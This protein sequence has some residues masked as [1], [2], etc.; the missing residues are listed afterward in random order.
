[1]PTHKKGHDKDK[2]YH[3]AKDQGYRSR[4]AYKLIQINKRYDFLGKAR[5]CI[6][7]CAAPGG[8]CQVASKF[9]P[10][11]SIVLGVDLLPIR[12]IRNVKTIVA[13]ITTAECR[14]QVTGELH[15]WKADVV[16][17]DGAPNIGSAYQKDAYVQN[18]LV[19]AALKCA[20]EH[21]IE[22]GTFCTKVYRSKDYNAVLW[23]LQQ[24]F[25]DV[26]AMKPNSSR[27]Q[28]SEIFLVCLKYLAPSTIDPKLLDPNHVF[29]EVQDPSDVTV[30]VLHKKY[31][32]HNKR[33]R[34]GYDESAGILLT[35]TCTVQ[36]F[37]ASKDPVRLLTDMNAFTYTP[38]CKELY[39][40][41]PATTED[42][43]LAF[44][45]LRV[46]GRIDFKKLLKWRLHIIK[47]KEKQKAS[48]DDSPED[49]EGN[50]E[51]SKKRTHQDKTPLTEEEIQI[52][53][54]Q[55][56]ENMDRQ[57][58]KEKKKTRLQAA[59]ERSR[60]A[61][62][63]SNASFGVEQDMELFSL[64]NEG[65]QT[66]SDLG[67]VD[68]VGLDE[69]PPDFDEAENESSSD[70][71]GADTGGLIELEEDGLEDQLEQD[72]LR[73]ASRERARKERALLSE[74][75]NVE[76]DIREGL[77]DRVLSTKKTKKQESSEGR[78]ASRVDEDDVLEGGDGQVKEDLDNYV[79]LLS[80]KKKV[81]GGSD[82]D[83]DSGSN[84]SDGDSEE[85]NEDSASED[86]EEVTRPKKKGK[87]DQADVVVSRD[88]QSS[89]TKANLWFSNP[90]FKETVV[91]SSEAGADS[92][93]A[94]KASKRSV[95]QKEDK[96]L[97]DLNLPLTDKQIRSL[98]RKKDMDK[99]ERKEERRQK[100]R[101][102]LS[103][104]DEGYVGGFQITPLE[105][106]NSK[107]AGGRGGDDGEEDEIDAET[108][109]VRDLIRRGMG[110]AAK[111]PDTLSK[112]EITP[113]PAYAPDD[114][115]ADDLSDAESTL[116]IAG[117]H[118]PRTY[119]SDDEVYDGHD[120]AMTLA[121]GT[122][123]L[124]QSR[125]KALVDASYNRFAWNDPGDLPTWFMDDEMRHNRPQIPVPNA[126]LDQVRS[127]CHPVYIL[128]YRSTGQ[129]EVP[130]E[131]DARN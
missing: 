49:L 31:D 97:Q 74:R 18:E 61:L 131:R 115:D 37:V 105:E 47:E 32:Q 29:K 68:E 69:L 110:A 9:M 4:A 128:T 59:K 78:V 2:Y 130:K 127:V 94:I 114:S 118:D 111:K 108:A 3:L 109:A 6:D 54:S 39:D 8:W 119:G 77:Y 89:R 63:I 88:E 117:R 65:I 123:M 60:Q 86:E 15:G 87:S 40:E 17:C 90:L 11:G 25:V 45:D 124:R 43:R 19:L 23:V 14:R 1:M 71:E 122:M 52:E 35:K 36:Q 98:K 104:E 58:R 125:K 91:S 83:S 13:D 76:D 41:H 28:S 100:L 38:A 33:H 99:K 34:T 112:L 96:I 42:I 57:K 7:L 70:A 62:G 22:G 53:I 30:D 12:A 120:K 126:L 129:G 72:Y 92:G 81:K 10:S 95:E 103:E 80:G 46:L 48:L 73:Y 93:K 21:L 121:L 51:V 113:A 55:Q 85:E 75:K 20:T 79:R 84:S 106:S 24:L 16:L 50:E 56:R 27:S 102:A 116:R 26:Q 44:A 66:R 67:G 82:S 64:G 107:E 5:V 101:L